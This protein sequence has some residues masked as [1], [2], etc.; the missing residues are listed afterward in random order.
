MIGLTEHEKYRIGR[1]AEAYNRKAAMLGLPLVTVSEGYLVN[2]DEDSNNDIEIPKFIR[3]IEKFKGRGHKKC[4]ELRLHSGI[5][6]IGSMAFIDF[7]IEKITARGEKVYSVLTRSLENMSY[8]TVNEINVGNDITEDALVSLA[9]ILKEKDLF[10]E[11]EITVGDT[12]DVGKYDI[13]VKK[14][15]H[16]LITHIYH[17]ESIIEIS[18]AVT[19][20]GKLDMRPEIGIACDIAQRMHECLSGNSTAERYITLLDMIEPLMSNI[21]KHTELVRNREKIAELY[22]EDDL[23][24]NLIGDGRIYADIAEIMLLDDTVYRQVSSSV[25]IEEIYNT[26][27]RMTDELRIPE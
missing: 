12:T 7:N 9:Y 22:T 18:V 11:S 6:D 1:T 19:K 13:D 10:S 24:L 14:L 15:V 8:C 3:Y 16:S 20:D 21:V 4:R 25:T 27:K 23:V 5:I 26:I 2:I 17:A